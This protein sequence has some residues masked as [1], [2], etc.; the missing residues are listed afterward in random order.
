MISMATEK[1]NPRTVRTAF[2]GL[3]SRL[4]R[5]IR[6][7]MDTRRVRPSRSESPCRNFGGDSGRMASAGGRVITWRK[8]D[9]APRHAAA[10]LIPIPQRISL[11]PA[12]KFNSGN[13][14]KF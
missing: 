2:Q 7:E 10:A 8:E 9:R 1:D 5:I 13:L 3:R 4:R 11:G 12:I 14:K 6:R